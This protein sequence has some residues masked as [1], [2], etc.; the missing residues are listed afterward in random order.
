MVE[1]RA[2]NKIAVWLSS[3]G[4]KF[5]EAQETKTLS[6]RITAEHCGISSSV[7]KMGT[8]ENR[9]QEEITFREMALND[10]LPEEFTHSNRA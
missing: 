7:K 1:A 6:E 10:S 8:L 5:L 3:I 9:T 4:E 2:R